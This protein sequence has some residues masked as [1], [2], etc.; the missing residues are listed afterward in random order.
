MKPWSHYK[1]VGVKYP[2]QYAYQQQLIDE[3]NNTPMTAA[4]RKAALA[5]VDSHV[6]KWFDEA[7]RP[8]N[9]ERQRLEDEF[10]ADARAELVYDKLLT[11]RGVATLEYLAYQRGRASGYAAVYEVLQGLAELVE[12]LCGEFLGF[13]PEGAA[14]E[15]APEGGDASDK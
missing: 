2:D 9:A 13:V 5:E 10:W 14:P 6:C 4:Q 3:I 1:V 8:W 15:A 12:N 11:D 7:V